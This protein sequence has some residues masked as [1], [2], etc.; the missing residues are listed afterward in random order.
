MCL[1]DVKNSVSLYV[2]SLLD[3]LYSMI[4]NHALDSVLIMQSQVRLIH[5]IMKSVPENIHY[6]SW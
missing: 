3:L 6:L 2:D 5:I 1:E 4:H